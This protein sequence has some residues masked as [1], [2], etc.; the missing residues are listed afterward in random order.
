MGMSGEIFAP[1]GQL[2]RTREV[3]GLAGDLVQFRAYVGSKRKYC[4]ERGRS[5]FKGQL[6]C[7]FYG[8]LHTAKHIGRHLR[9]AEGLPEVL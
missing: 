4:P 3:V 9:V 6:L 2:E 5:Q 7:A 8:V 1:V